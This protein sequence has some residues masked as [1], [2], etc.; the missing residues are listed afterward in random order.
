MELRP[1]KIYQ[2]Y[3]KNNLDKFSATK[4]LLSLIESSENSKTRVDSIK[5]LE[6]IG[7]TDKYIFKILEKKKRIIPNNYN[8]NSG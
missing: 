3:L 8:T 1:E 2:E 5:E 6:C 7:A 4:L